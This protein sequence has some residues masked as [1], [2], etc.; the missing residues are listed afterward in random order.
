MIALLCS[1]A[2]HGFRSFLALE[3]PKAGGLLPNDT[4]VE[5]ATGSIA[6]HDGTRRQTVM[7]PSA[8]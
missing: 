8:N 1:L 2:S 4:V 7:L 5:A 3:I 6:P